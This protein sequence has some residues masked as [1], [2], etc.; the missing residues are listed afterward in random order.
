MNDLEPVDL[1]RAGSERTPGVRLA[2]SARGCIDFYASGVWILLTIVPTTPNPQMVR[3]LRNLVPNS[4]RRAG[5]ARF[6]HDLQNDFGP[7][8]FEQQGGMCAISGLP[9]SLNEFP[10]VLVKRPFAPSLDRISSQRGYTADNVRL[11]CVAVNFGMGQWGEELYLTLARAAVAHSDRLTASKIVSLVALG[12]ST[13]D[14]PTSD[15][16]FLQRE[17]LAAAE[18]IAT[19][20]SGDPLLRQRRRIASLERSLTLG[21]EGL[22]LAGARAARARAG[23]ILPPYPG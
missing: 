22:K 5:I 18:T 11:V 12:R 13:A 17:R 7:G 6:A 23:S 9:F 21:P 3:W 20:L 8:L 10:L 4:R 14:E 1:V 16:F 2:L 15:W 19:T